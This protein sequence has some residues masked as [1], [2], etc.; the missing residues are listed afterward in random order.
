MTTVRRLIELDTAVDMRLSELAARRGQEVAEVI[1]EAIEVL[2]AGSFLEGPDVSEDERRLH[3]FLRT[4]KAIPF[5]D[6][7]AWTESWGTEAELP[8]PSGRGIE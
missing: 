3:E 4:R 5:E 7:K 2:E 1:A 6:V 8:R